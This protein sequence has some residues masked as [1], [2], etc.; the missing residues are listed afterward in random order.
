MTVACN[1]LSHSYQI[2]YS[3]LNVSEF[4][5]KEF[6]AF[7]RIKDSDNDCEVI[8]LGRLKNLHANHICPRRLHSVKGIIFKFL[9]QLWRLSIFI[10]TGLF[11]SFRSHMYIYSLMHSFDDIFSNN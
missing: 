7:L 2:L 6:K 8:S 5:N 4:P 3:K 1:R 11:I 10:R 9:Q